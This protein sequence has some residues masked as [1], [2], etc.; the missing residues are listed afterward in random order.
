[1]AIDNLNFY[2]NWLPAG[3]L[4]DKYSTQP[5]C[6]R[7]KN[8]DI[9]SSSKSTKATA[10]S[11]PVAWDSWVIASEWWLELRADGKVYDST[12]TLVVDPTTD[13]PVYPISYD[14]EEWTYADA[15]R[16]TPQAMSVA[17]EWDEWK[18]FIVFTD[19]ASYNY[20]E[21]PYVVPKK[22]T[23]QYLVYRWLTADWYKFSKPSSAYSSRNMIIKID[24]EN[25]PLAEPRKLKVRAT[26]GLSSQTW[27]V[28]LTM[29]NVPSKFYY[30]KQTDTIVPT[31]FQTLDLMPTW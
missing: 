7:S 11:S 31:D 17:S 6:L 22:E 25:N 8:L 15:Q 27:T 18:S 21:V 28:T 23:K 29:S 16:W 5:W 30:D 20:S 12:W 2:S 1:M 19:R 14:W 9:F 10:F 26:G 24:T 13:F 4:T 3:Q